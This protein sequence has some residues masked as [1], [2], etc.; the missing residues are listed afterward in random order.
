M[1][2]KLFDSPWLDRPH[3]NGTG[4]QKIYKFPNG[5]GASVV[6]FSLGFGRYGSYTDNE[7][8]WELAVIK[9]DGN[10]YILTYDTPITDD[11]IGHL[12]TVKVEEKLKK[13]SQLK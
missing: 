3:P 7:S 9:F 6:R 13:I 2:T 11:V 8:E 10:D 4:I 5:Y 12:S 1:H